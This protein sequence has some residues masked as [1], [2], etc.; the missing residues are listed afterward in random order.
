E[1]LH[2]AT[3]FTTLDLR[4]G[5]WQIP[6]RK[7]DIHKTAFCPGANMPLF[8]FTRMPFGLHS[9]TAT[10]QSLMDRKLGHLPFVKVYLDD[11]LIASPDLKTHL[12]HLRIV[13]RILAEA[14]LTLNASKCEFAAP[15]VHYLGH[16][17]DGHGTRPDPDRVDTIANWAPP[18]TVTEIKQFLGLVGYYREFIPRFASIALPIQR[19]TSTCAATPNAIQEHWSAE[20]DE[21]FAILKRALMDL[22]ALSYPD[23]DMPFE[24]CCDASNYAIGAVLQQE[25]RPLS[26]FSQSLSG[27]QLRW[28]TFEKEGFALFRALQKFRHY[29]LGHGLVVTIFSDHRPLQHLAKCESPR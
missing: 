29:V 28:H 25:G 3:V 27:P 14:N 18:T 24:I 5:Y 20:C 21:R 22:P 2:G 9:A 23:F 11:I 1:G 4:S 16:I 13:F 10:F 7:E 19:L 26:F 12:E 6:L 17:F 8:E 15:S